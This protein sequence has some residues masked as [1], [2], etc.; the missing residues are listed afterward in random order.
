M[1]IVQSNGWGSPADLRPAGLAALG[2]AAESV[3]VVI[4][5]HGSRR[6]ESNDLLLQVAALFRQTTGLPIVE[7]AHM[8]LA[9]PSIATAF[10]RAVE[11]GARL[12]IVHPYFLA[13]GR[14][15]R[16]DIP[17]LAADAAA[18][19]PGIR[20][21]VTAPL[22]SASVDATG[23]AR[24]RPAVFAAR[25]AG[26]GEVRSV[27]GRR[28]VSPVAARRIAAGCPWSAHAIAVMLRCAQ[29]SRLTLHAYPESPCRGARPL[30]LGPI[31]IL[32]VDAR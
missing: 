24:A 19:H 7:P 28:H 3:G 11:Q 5:D 8:E 31:R 25:A 27:H 6:T 1:S 26:G 9:E 20:Y 15:W 30:L 21:L 12:V 18:R 4:V 22:G 14:H 32:A 2:L 17:R 29:Y 16:Q 23:D 10:A 13:P